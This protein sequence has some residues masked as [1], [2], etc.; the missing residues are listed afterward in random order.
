MAQKRFKLFSG[1]VLRVYYV[2]CSERKFRGKSKESVQNINEMQV[3][4][5]L[6]EQKK[7]TGFRQSPLL[8]RHI[9]C[10]F[11]SSIPYQDLGS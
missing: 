1:I 5:M 10:G 4:G 9:N 11:Y 7:G 2:S 3:V 8:A 6:V